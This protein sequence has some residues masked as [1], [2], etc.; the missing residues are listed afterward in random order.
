MT[1]RLFGQWQELLTGSQEEF[2]GHLMIVHDALADAE[3]RLQPSRTCQLLHRF[4]PDRR[5]HCHVAALQF[6]GQD[7]AQSI[8]G[9]LPLATFLRQ[10][11]G[12]VGLHQNADGVRLAWTED[13]GAVP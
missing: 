12:D 4:F 8:P 1:D 9:L 13:R 2:D 7:L 5:C 3:G 10:R 11:F 6:I